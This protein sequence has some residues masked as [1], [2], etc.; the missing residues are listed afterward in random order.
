MTGSSLW[1]LGDRLAVATLN[2]LALLAVFGCWIGSATEVR[3]HDT[4]YWLQGGIVAVVVASVADALWL[5]AG[6]RQ[7]RA[8][9][10]EL[11]RRWPAAAT[12]RIPTQQHRTYVTTDR[13]TT[14]HDPK[15][16]LVKGK[17]V[18]EPSKKDTRVPCGMCLS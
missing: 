16:L 7:L 14:Y 5:L 9:R 8:G 11:A 17:S 2:G 12:P 3:F 6:L 18:R 15:C 4:L 13:M 10:R 1:A